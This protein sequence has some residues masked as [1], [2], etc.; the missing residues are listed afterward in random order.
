MPA[1]FPVA[2]KHPARPSPYSRYSPWARRAAQHHRR[3]RYTPV[4][5]AVASPAGLHLPCHWSARRLWPHSC[6]INSI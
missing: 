1:G 6:P 3:T 4:S 2:S 5:V